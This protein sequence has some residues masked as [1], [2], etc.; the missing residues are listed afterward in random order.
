MIYQVNHIS[1]A[2]AMILA[3][4]VCGCRGTGDPSE[5]NVADATSPSPGGTTP[6][7]LTAPRQNLSPWRNDSQHLVR[8]DEERRHQDEPHD[9]A[10]AR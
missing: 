8:L 7:S 3:A 6:V 5:V 1:C 4:G 2:L 9:R 10:T